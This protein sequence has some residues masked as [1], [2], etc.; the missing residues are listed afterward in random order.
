MLNKPIC[1]KSIFSA[2][3]NSEQTLDQQAN[4]FYN[5]CDIRGR[6]ISFAC[7]GSTG[8][9]FNNLGIYLVIV[10]AIGSMDDQNGDI[11]INLTKNDQPIDGAFAV[12][13]SSEKSKN[14]TL[15][16]SDIITVDK[17]N[18]LRDV[19]RVLNTGVKA[20]FTLMSIRIVKII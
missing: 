6:S 11:K 20:I 13:N 8:I 1:Q 5:D 18:S 9:K 4:L 17:E 19:Y 15:T 12:S 14:Q 16:F 2:W 7:G 10:T 3:T